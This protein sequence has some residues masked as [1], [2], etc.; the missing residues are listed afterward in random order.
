[1]SAPVERPPLSVVIAS[2]NRARQLDECLRRLHAVVGPADEVVVVDSC[3]SD[4]ST[5][6]TAIA[7]GASVVTMAAPGASSARNA[8]WRAARHELVAFLD[9]DVMVRSGWADAMA[10]A[11]SQDGVAFVTGW[12]GVPAGQEDVPGPLPLMIDPEARPLTAATEGAFG[13]GA[14]WGARRSALETVGGFDER[15]GPGRW[16]AAAEDVDL[17]DRLVIAGLPGRYDPRIRID[18]DMWRGRR[19]RL[20]LHWRYGKGMGARL[21]KLAALDR[22][23]FHRERRDALWTYGTRSL[24]HELA[25]RWWGGA[26]CTGLR[27]TSTLMGL[28]VGWVTV[29]R[30]ASVRAT[31]T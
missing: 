30:G 23:R 7:R 18:H 13:A 1:V 4:D 9:D 20:T 24:G 8:G 12:I 19:E 28:A 14:N 3:S 11:L 2:R 17:F 25:A 6:R 21:A 27:L 29:R 31:S 15:L 16:W 10:V 22:G 5:R 26:L